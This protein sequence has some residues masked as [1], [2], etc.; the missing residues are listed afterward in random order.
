MKLAKAVPHFELIVIYKGKPAQEVPYAM[1]YESESV[2][3]YLFALS[4]VSNLPTPILRKALSMR[5]LVRG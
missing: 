4:Y 5:P 3:A 2:G 1:F